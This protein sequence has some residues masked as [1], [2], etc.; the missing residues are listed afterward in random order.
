[1]ANNDWLQPATE[2]KLEKVYEKG[3]IRFT[4]YFLS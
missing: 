4:F 3:I 1:M 2:M